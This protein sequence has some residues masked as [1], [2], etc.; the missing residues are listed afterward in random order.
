MILSQSVAIRL[1]TP[2]GII[3]NMKRKKPDPIG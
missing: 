3:P 2:A 1:A